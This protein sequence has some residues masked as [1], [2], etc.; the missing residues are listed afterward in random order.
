MKKKGQG[1]I[2]IPDEIREKVKVMAVEGHSV[3]YIAKSLSISSTAVHQIEKETDNLEQLRTNKKEEIVKTLWNKVKIALSFIDSVKLKK[4]SAYQ[5]MTIAAIA[6][7]KAQLLTGEATEILGVKTE[8][9]INKQLG[10]LE[11]AEKELQEA[12]ARAT[13]KRKAEE[14]EKTKD[15]K[16]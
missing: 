2:R 15:G 11:R 9:E 10:E 1:H 7:D 16:S 12:W 5:L 6:V 14:K 8:A 4:S 13:A 3:R